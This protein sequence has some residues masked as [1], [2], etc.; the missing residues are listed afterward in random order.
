MRIMLSRMRT[1]CTGRT[2]LLATG[3]DGFDDIRG[4]EIE[5]LDARDEGLATLKRPASY[6]SPPHEPQ[7]RQ[8]ALGF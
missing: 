8:S 1:A 4:E 5:G 2:S 3:E 6:S 7:L